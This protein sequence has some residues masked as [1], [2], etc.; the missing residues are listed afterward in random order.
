M[1]LGWFGM[2]EDQHCDISGRTPEYGEAAAPW[3]VTFMICHNGQE[4]MTGTT[5]SYSYQSEAGYGM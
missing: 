2:E 3:H 4:D 1:M 5:L